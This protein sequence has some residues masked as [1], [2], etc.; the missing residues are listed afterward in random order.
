MDASLNPKKSSGP[1]QADRRPRDQEALKDAIVENLTYGVG[2]DLAH[3]TRWDWYKAVALAVRDRVVDNWMDTTRRYYKK[4]QKRVYYLSLEFLIGRLLQS[5]MQNIGVME[6]VRGALKS[7]GVDLSD[8]LDTEPDAALGN[9]GLGRLAACFLDSMATIGVAGYGY[10]IRYDYG[11][12]RQSFQDG[13]QIESPE[14]WLQ[15]GNPWEF[16]RPEVAYI[17]PFFGRVEEGV[18]AV[19][20]KKTHRWVDTEKILAVA[21]DTPVVGWGGETINT[22][23][24][25][26]AKPENEFEMEAFNKG[27]YI[28]AVAHQVLAQN[29]SRVLYPN[30]NTP[31]GQEL[32]FKQEFF[33]TSA[34][35]QDMLRRFK[36]HHDD[37]SEL[38]EKAAVQLNDTHPAIAVAELMRLLM[39]N[40]GLDWSTAWGLTRK[41]ISYTNHTLLPEAL[42]RWPVGLV[43]RLLPRHMQIIYDINAEFLAEARTKQGADDTRLARLSLIDEHGERSV[44]MGNLAFVGSHKVNGVSALHTQLMK[45][46]VFHDLHREFPDRITNKTNGITPR[47]WLAGCNPGLSHLITD[48]IGDGWQADLERLE[49]LVPLAD[50]AE[51]R[52]RFA[53][54]K[55]ANKQ[56]MADII[57][58]RLGFAVDPQ[59]M[60]DVQIKRIHEY[61]RQ[62]LNLLETVA[63]YNAIKEN[64]NG[65]W[66]PR[67]KIFGGKAAAG[68]FQA[69]LIIKLINDVART[70]NNDPS[71]R[72]LLKIAFLPNYNVSSAEKIIPAADLSEQISTAGKEASGTGNMKFALNGALTIGTLDG[73]NVEIR[74]HVGEE[75]IYIFGLTAEEV[76]ALRAGNRFDPQAKVSDT[77]ALKR[78]LEM[79]RSGVFSPDD[80]N[81]FQPIVDSL[82]YHDTF[83]L[84]AD[85]QDYYDT[86]R[87]IDADFADAEGWHRKAILNTARVGWFSADR[88]V[89]DYAEEI[90]DA[91]PPQGLAAE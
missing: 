30:D 82:L 15:F 73:A 24:L 55:L 81:R 50:D 59:A 52:S 91:L 61:K 9:G 79:V 77:P 65:D 64:P 40:E 13:H 89:A 11:M 51:F 27:D 46:T 3:A 84:T 10:G 28:G 41:V 18:D 74:D 17:V 80:R 6:E 4:D 35:L 7:L 23:R 88:T 57:Q 16:E 21:Y 69:K 39:D 2:K 62:H 86:Q 42:E 58:E 66:Q 70:V 90:W 48:A 5:A 68:Y 72:D 76:Q 87:R 45:R 26:A 1:L 75:N 19:T 33:F 44:R 67:V 12:F 37:W 47:R 54:V 85:F 71:I 38:P 63:L 49:R 14:D 60:F 34:S 43:E 78:A 25:W 29:I 56:V 53:K 83:L 22:L 20:G 8:I 36:D 32:R 31:V